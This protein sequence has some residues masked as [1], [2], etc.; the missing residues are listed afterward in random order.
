LRMKILRQNGNISE[1]LKN[2][3]CSFEY[4]IVR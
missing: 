4:L 2:A 3:E 1:E